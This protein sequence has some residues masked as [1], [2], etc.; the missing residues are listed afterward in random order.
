M[1]ALTGAWAP[2]SSL[3]RTHRLAPGYIPLPSLV[4]LP[5]VSLRSDILVL[6]V[7]LPLFCTCLPT[8]QCTVRAGNGAN[9]SF[10][11]RCLPRAGHIAAQQMFAELLNELSL[12]VGAIL[13]LPDTKEELST[14]LRNE[15]TDGLGQS[16]AG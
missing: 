2:T 12:G 10:Q 8:S 4:T 9:S 5:E 3:W 15:M 11:P 13:P 1:S 14:C 7:L 6:T 16:A